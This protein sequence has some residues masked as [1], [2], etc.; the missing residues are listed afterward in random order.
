MEK[1]YEF[2]REKLSTFAPRL[3]CG[4]G[5]KRL[6]RKGNQVIAGEKISVRYRLDFPN[7]A[8]G[9]Y[10]EVRPEDGT[11]EITGHGDECI[12]PPC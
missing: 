9:S 12:H 4:P 2:P 8:D 6:F 5:S 7:G 1:P 3:P 10:S 11:G